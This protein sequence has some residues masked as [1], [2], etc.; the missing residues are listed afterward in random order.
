MFG[1][2]ASTVL[3]IHWINPNPSTHY[4]MGWGF[5][6][7]GVLPQSHNKIISRSQESQLSLKQVKIAYFCWFCF[8]SAH[9][10]MVVDTHLDPSMEIYQNTSSGYRVNTGAGGVISH[11]ITLISPI[12]NMADM[13]QITQRLS[14]LKQWSLLQIHMINPNPSTHG[15]M[16]WGWA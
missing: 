15:D 4:A 1:P 7:T 9:L 13:D 8:I 6:L 16:G 3:Q 11:Q 10:P 5:S 14:C 12:F 2:M